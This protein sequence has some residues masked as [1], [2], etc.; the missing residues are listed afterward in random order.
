MYCQRSSR[1][2][3]GLTSQILMLQL[4][5]H[6]GDVGLHVTCFRP[7]IRC[8]FLSEHKALNEKAMN[9]VTEAQLIVNCISKGQRF[10]SQRA[11][12]RIKRYT[13]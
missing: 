4:L 3:K 11:R 7:R 6:L 13:A 9:F 5:A 1:W 8:V 10:E 2:P 12:I